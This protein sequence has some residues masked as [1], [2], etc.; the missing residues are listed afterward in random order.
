[1]RNETTGPTTAPRDPHL[2]AVRRAFTLLSAAALITAVVP[3]V[4]AYQRPGRTEMVSVSNTGEPA[5]DGVTVAS[6]SADASVVA[7][8]TRAR[9][10][11]E[12]VDRTKP[13]PY[14]VY[15]RDRATGVTEWISRP[16]D[17]TLPDGHS[18]G[19]RVSP[20]GRFVMFYSQASNIVSGDTNERRDVFLHDRAK[21]TNER[22][23]VG[24]S[25]EQ[26][27]SDSYMGDVGAGGRYIAFV[28][29]APVVPGDTNGQGDVIV[30]DRATGAYEIASV[31]WDGSPADAWSFFP[32]VSADGRYVAFQSDATNLVPGDDN[33]YQ[34]IFVR[35][36]LTGSTE[37]VS[38]STSGEQSNDYSEWPRISADGS[39]VAFTSFASNLVPA[40]LQ[41]CVW[42]NYSV[43]CG[44]V[45]VRDLE[46]G[47]TERVSVT[48]DGGEANEESAA[49][50]IS[51][52]GRW[53][54]F[55]TPADNID[56]DRIP[57]PFPDWDAYV[58]DRLTGVT[59]RIALA[60]DGSQAEDASWFPAP[61][62]DARYVA[63][64]SGASN[65]V[66]GDEDFKPALFM[67]DRG[68]EIGVGGLDVAAIGEQVV[69]SGWARL[70]GAV[71]AARED[72]H[73][74]GGAGASEV[75]T[76]LTGASVVVRPE[77]DDLLLRL[78][79]VRLPT[80]HPQRPVS[81][82]GVL[83]GA[84]IAPGVVWGL[85]F[86][87]DDVRH[88]V[89]ASRDTAQVFALY[90]CPEDC[91]KVADLVGGIGTIGEAV[92]VSVP[93]QTLGIADGGRLSRVR[94]FAGAGDVRSGALTVVDDILMPAIDLEPAG[95]AIGIAP[96]GTLQEQ[97]VFGT[98]AALVDG[99]FDELLD[100]AGLPSGSYEV[101]ARAC[102]NDV[103][104]ARSARVD[105]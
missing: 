40:D 1:M 68:P 41:E 81:G 10:L 35:D 84:A 93:L 8:D 76:E 44:D 19:T 14:N 5:E 32:S 100:G 74:D 77:L 66:P 29:D 39:A 65:L 55:H 6:M 45:F 71:L 98:Q 7:F 47:I 73:S 75:G 51:A 83:P 34:D 11:V 30:V 63:F 33:A 89:R 99:R 62:A 57:P 64:G 72:A 25:G 54:S 42:P 49:T 12:G 17:A 67:R 50:G 13:F 80:V 53:V 90:R 24:P 88:E 101:W 3:S 23:S 102:V 52:D 86:E 21:G 87:L 96:V 59:E 94:A 56:P 48:N 22:V 95:V 27:D 43:N 36:L 60:D 38:V 105:L 85:S 70:G 15:V 69:A 103:C 9:N 82:V 20:D 92:V 58:R 79:A 18:R 61:S 104:G 28:T 16:H 31:A 97:V 37:L 4:S 78:D 2:R 91:E 26:L 46:A